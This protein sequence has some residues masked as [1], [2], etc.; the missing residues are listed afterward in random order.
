MRGV[1]R[2]DIG[3]VIVGE[4]FANFRVGLPR[5]GKC[6][7]LEHP[8]LIKG[9]QAKRTPFKHRR[10]CINQRRNFIGIGAP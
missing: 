10:R 2:M 1:M 9:A 3:D 4:Q 6:C 5:Q 7:V 8:A